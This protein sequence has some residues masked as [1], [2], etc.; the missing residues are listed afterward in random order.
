MF[1]VKF[2]VVISIFINKVRFGTM[3]FNIRVIDGIDNSL[4]PVHKALFLG[5]FDHE[6]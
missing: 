4:E 6:Q 5:K 1:F 3:T 2:F